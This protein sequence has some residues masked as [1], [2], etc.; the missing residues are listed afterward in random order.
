MKFNFIHA[1][2]LA[3]AVVGCVDFIAAL[4]CIL[5]ELLMGAI[6]TGIIATAIAFVL[7]GLLND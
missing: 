5:N 7:G 3:A 1:A 2:M 4:V 6:C